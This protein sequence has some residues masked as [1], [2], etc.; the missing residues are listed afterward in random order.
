[1]SDMSVGVFQLS[2]LLAALGDWQELWVTVYLSLNE[3]GTVQVKDDFV[4]R[5]W[6][7]FAITS[8]ML[9]AAAR[10]QLPTEGDDKSVAKLFADTLETILDRKVG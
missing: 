7:S 5:F 4:D 3:W 10:V 8:E 9:R 1:M 6:E 2:P